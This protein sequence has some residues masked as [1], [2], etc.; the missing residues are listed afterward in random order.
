[1]KLCKLQIPAGRVDRITGQLFE[2]SL[3]Q[4]GEALGHRMQVTAATLDSVL[5][6]IRG[7][8][9]AGYLTHGGPEFDRLLFEIG[10]FENF[11]IV[12]DKLIA[13]VFTAFESF[14]KNERPKFERLFDVAENVPESFGVSAVFEAEF[15][16]ETTEGNLVSVTEEKPADCAFEFPT[17]ICSVLHSFDFVDTP[18]A[19]ADGLFLSVVDNG[20]LLR[21]QTL[22]KDLRLAEAEN[23]VEKLAQEL[24]V[25]AKEISAS[26][27]KVS[28]ANLNE[29]QL[30]TRISELEKLGSNPVVPVAEIQ[31]SKILNL[32][33]LISE[34]VKNNPGSSRSTAVLAIGKSNPEIFNY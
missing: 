27:E 4:T 1:M 18:A 32:G 20:E 2:V 12:G 33:N 14:I 34:F 26:N 30:S 13:D 31:I 24:A 22:E 3:M 29:I 16:W 11:R 5:N 7:R 9:V 6:Q 17:A 23:K 25:A 8:S 15:F 28:A 19:N 10:S 21:M